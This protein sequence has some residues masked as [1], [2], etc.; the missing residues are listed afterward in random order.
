MKITVANGMASV[1]SS[2]GS[3]AISTKCTFACFSRN[4]A[5]TPYVQN[6]RVLALKQILSTGNGKGTRYLG[7]TKKV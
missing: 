5:A 2:V 3:I 6:A 4:S 1:A 7:F